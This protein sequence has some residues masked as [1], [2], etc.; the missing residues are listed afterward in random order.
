MTPIPE[1]H[2]VS[3]FLVYYL[4]ISMQIGIGILGFQRIIAMS[5]G[6]DAWI[7]VIV[8]GLAIHIIIWMIYKIN[9]SAEDDLITV[10]VNLL[11][12][13]MG[14][15]ISFIFIFYFCMLT[16]TTIRTYIEVIQV[17]MFPELSTFWFSLGFILLAIYIVY[18]GFRTVTGI[19]FFGAVLPAYLILMFGFTI[20]YSDP[21]NMLP[22][23]DHSFKDL[24]KASKDMALTY[25]GYEILLFVYPFIKEPKRSKKWAHLAVLTTTVLYTLLTFVTFAYFSEGQLQKN[26][27]ATLAMWKIVELPFVE[28][29]E[30]IGIANWNLIILPNVCIPLWI[31]SRIL[32]K[33]VNLRQ[34]KGVL[35]VSIFSL[36]VVNLFSGREQVNMLNNYLG[37]F[38]LYL[39]YGYIPL[40]FIV[41]S[42]MKRVKKN[43]N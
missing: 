4:I 13:K 33:T 32:K 36:I 15:F 21:T 6:Y 42:I 23:L 28:R 7:S 17:W 3:S 12:K 24:A 27:W 5:A 20:P 29:F 25:L 37:K 43:A 39:N 18:G 38:S 2:K 16:V 10:H 41:V 30:Y 1:R 11:G 9:E 35:F 22:I 26:I 34:R 31:A 14:N 8:A 40:L 19:A